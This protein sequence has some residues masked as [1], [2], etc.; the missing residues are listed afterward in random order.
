MAAR[1]ETSELRE[2]LIASV[3]KA[4]RYYATLGFGSFAAGNAEGGLSTNAEIAEM[5]ASGAHMTLF[6]TGRGS[7]VGSALASVIK[8]CAN[9]E[10]YKNLREDMDVNAGRIL[11]GHPLSDVSDEIYDLI[12]KIANGALTKSENSGHS[13]FI[14]TYK[15]FEPVGP[16][17]LPVS[18]A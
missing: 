8:I 14:L 15:S 12:L 2:E 13:E 18:I 11:E 16:A 7:V 1:A 6:T 10:T 17:C 9:P 3:D 4:A 5:I